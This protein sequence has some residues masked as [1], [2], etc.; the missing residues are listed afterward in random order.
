MPKDQLLELDIEG[1]TCTACARR[2]EKNLNK[3]EGVVAYVDFA[4]EKAHLQLGKA[5][6]L[7]ILEKAVSDAGYKVAKGKSEL[8]S[9]KPRLWIGGTLSVLAMLF[10]MIPALGFHGVEFLL[11]GLATPVFFYVAFPFHSAAIKNLRHFD[12]T[13]DTL[14]S[15]GSSIAYG[16][17]IYLVITGSMHTYFEVSAVVPT[18]VLLG[19]FI[20]VRARRSATD[21]VRALLSAIPETATIERN[22]QRQTIPSNQIQVGDIVFVAAGERIPADGKLLSSHA[23]LDNSTLTGESLPVELKE[24]DLVS[25]GATSLAGQIA[26]EATGSAATSRLSRIA[27]LVREATAQKSKIASI[28]DRISKV[29]VPSVI[30]LSAI[31]YLVWT[32]GF[33]DQVAGFEASVAVL[34]IACPC[35]LGI[36]VPMSLVVAT[37]IGAKRSVVIRN[38]D[39]LADLAKIKRVV[40]D[41]TGTLTDG[42]LRVLNSRGL[43]GVGAATML[44]YASALERGS[45]HPVALAISKISDLKTAENIREIPGQGLVGAVEGLTIAVEKPMTYENQAELDEAI[46]LAGPN[47][48][49][50]VAWEG[51]AHGLIELGDSLK[52]KASQAIK[53]LKQM[54]ISSSILSGDNP[55]R[56]E[57]IAKELGAAEYLGGISPE[58]KLQK[59]KSLENTAM[60]GDGINDVAALSAATVGIAMGSGAHAAQAA[61]AITILDDDPLAIPF[62]LKLSAKTSKNIKQNLGWAFGYNILLIPVAALG[63]LNPMLA[64]VAM[65]FSSVSVVANALRLK[66]QTR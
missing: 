17:S 49:V 41:K 4:T 8:Q 33:G 56:V 38:P 3:V 60:V 45:K 50:V 35:A 57:A 42:K 1:M 52:P 64:G 9:L 46:K 30:T 23:S 20:E 58:G 55:A 13:M 2:V 53:A 18:V 65:A 43:G 27:D 10:G 22:A 5:V 19:R 16:Y 12:S 54:G 37:S 48:L 32:F 44:A 63:L 39:S 66:W 7:D 25:A 59:L 29:F 51:W 31:T 34:V 15:L 28:T 6:A 36:A 11:W 47:T 26:I 62:A 21:A 61:S 24:G 14:V 40:F